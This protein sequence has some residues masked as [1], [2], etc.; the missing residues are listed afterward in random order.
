[1]ITE[2]TTDSLYH[3][4]LVNGGKLVSGIKEFNAV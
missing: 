4:V 2:G 1:M 3:T